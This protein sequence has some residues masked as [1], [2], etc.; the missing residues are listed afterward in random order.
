[1]HSIT[2]NKYDL[3]KILNRAKPLS[4][5]S[6]YSF[7]QYL[8]VTIAERQLTLLATD[9]ENIYRATIPSDSFLADGRFLLPFGPLYS[10][11]Q[12]APSDHLTLYEVDDGLI[13][14]SS[15]PATYKLTTLPRCS[16]DDFPFVDLP[17]AEDYMELDGPQLER[18]IAIATSIPAVPSDKRAHVE[19]VRVTVHGDSRC[20]V[21]ASTDGARLA[22]CGADIVAPSDIPPELDSMVVLPSKK[23]LQAAVV[24]IR[25]FK[26]VNV[27]LW[28]GRLFFAVGQDILSLRCLEGQFPNT[29]SLL[30]GCEK[31][32]RI[33]IPLETLRAAAKRQSILT[34]ANYN[35]LNLSATEGGM[36]IRNE[37]PDMGESQEE[38]ALDPESVARLTEAMGEGGVTAINPRYLYAAL[39]H[40]PSE[41]VEV[42]CGSAKNP[43]LFKEPDSGN[44]RHVVMPMSN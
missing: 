33:K 17:P 8:H 29:Q 39:E 4:V 43:W 1:M 40:I 10:I 44:Y 26:R 2:L 23:G 16:A 11:V 3:L 37:N 35:R 30:D 9:V 34:N 19:G 32:N 15:G 13:Q 12:A 18:A 24:F 27:A 14:I 21:L 22:L 20:M 5:K 28:S 6:H 7:T 38:I 31:Q 41:Y 25:G 42:H 36:L